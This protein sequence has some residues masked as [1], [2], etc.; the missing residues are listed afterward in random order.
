M[1]R[2]VPT[3][4]VIASITASGILWLLFINSTC[5]CLNFIVCPCFTVYNFVVWVNLCSSSLFFI[6]EIVNCVAYIGILI[7]FNIYGIAPIWSSCPCVIT[8]PL[9]FSL[10]FTKYVTSGITKSTPNM[11][12]PGNSSPQSTSIISSSYSKTVMF[13]PISCNPPRGIIFRFDFLKLKSNFSFL[14]NLVFVFFLDVIFSFSCW[15]TFSSSL[16]FLLT[17]PF[18]LTE[19]LAFFSF[20]S[21][22]SFCFSSFCF[23]SFV[24]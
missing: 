19:Y 6:S 2:I 12:S 1:W 9:I 15:A 11:S 21:V 24:I 10:F 14:F 3:G 17:L 22:F 23:N 8:N 16:L 5:I 20:L 4:V 7:C 18:F 13:L